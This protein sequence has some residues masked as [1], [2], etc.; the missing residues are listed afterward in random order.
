MKCSRFFRPS[1]SLGLALLAMLV[2]VPRTQAQDA[3]DRPKIEIVRS[4]PHSDDITSVAFSA[5]GASMLSGS[6]DKKVKLW[7]AATGALLRTLEG[8]SNAVWSVAFSPDGARVLSADGKVR[9]W[10]AA[11]GVVL[12]TFEGG[13][14]SAEFA[15]DGARVLI[16]DWREV[17]LWDA[18][19]GALLRTFE[20]GGAPAKFSP[21]GARVLTGSGR[22]VKLWDAARGALLRTFESSADIFSVAFS[23]DGSRVLSGGRSRPRPL[24]PPGTPLWGPGMPFNLEGFVNTTRSYADHIKLWDAATGALLRTFEHNDYNAIVRSVAFSPDGTRVLSGGTADLGGKSA[25]ILWD[26]ANMATS[27]PLRTFEGHSRSVGSVAFSPDGSR[28]LSGGDDRTV[29]LWDAATGAALHFATGLGEGWGIA[30]VA[31]SPDGARVLSSGSSGGTIRLRDAATGAQIRTFEGHSRTVSSVA[32]SPNGA[33]VLSSSYDETVRWWDAATGALVCTI[34]RQPSDDEL[35]GGVDSVALSP[36]GSRALLSGGW[37]GV[38]SLWDTTTCTKLRSFKGHSGKVV[39]VAFS[40]DGAR[41]LSGSNDYITSRG[42]SMR[43]WD[44]ATG[45]QLRTFE[46]SANVLSVAFS[47]DGTRVLSGGTDRTVKLWNPDGWWPS[48][49]PL[50]TFKGHSDSVT[51]VAFSPDGARVL[52]GSRDKT[53][54]LW[55]AATG[56][57]LRTF[58][59][60]SDGV[61]SIAFSADGRRIVSASDDATVLIW[62][63]A[64][65]AL[66]AS[67]IDGRDGRW[68][69]LTPAGF[70]TS[71][72]SVNDLLGIVRGL[73]LTTIDQVHQSLYNPDLVREAL[74]GDPGGEMAEAAK[75]VDLEKVLDSG[76]PPRVA[77]VSPTADS[78]SV[79]D[80]T[81]VVARIENRGKGVGRIEW[82]VNG[83]TAAV[84]AKPEGRGPV[85]T[86]T[87]QLSLD[88]GD[89]AIE[90]VAYN[91]SNLLASLPARITVKS[92]EPAGK[93]KPKLHI[94]AI[95][96][97]AY[98][99]R[100]WMP[101]GSEAPLG[102][103]PLDL[104]VKDAKAFAASMEKAAAGLYDKVRV[105]LALD[106]DASRDNLLKLI[107]KVAAQIH[108]RDTFI[109]FAAAHGY[110]LRGRF[111]LIPQDHQGGIN[112][113]ALAKRAIGQD[114]LQDWL[115][116]RIKAKRALI[117]LDACESGA[118]I[119]GHARSRTD[120]PASEAAVG[121]LHEAT[122]RP[123]LTAA[124]V[125]Q[126]AHEGEVGASGETHGYFTWAVLDALRN[127]DTN[128]NDLIELSELVSHVQTSV[129]RIAA[130]RG[131]RGQAVVSAPAGDKQAARFGSRGEDFVV[132]RRLQ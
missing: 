60:H 52:S 90:V 122:G 51:S 61:R 41:V 110:S 8:H 114:E 107:D 24:E 45:A 4:I 83:I 13:G 59:G 124:A 128:G 17:R 92:T 71:S 88:Q 48:W 12:R 96:I 120:G 31:F 98:E 42:Y 79:A 54:H 66:L 87:R 53:I 126:S 106:R 101:P 28:V 2:A 95:G 6:R 102:F 109:L 47:P 113:E 123:V 127:G 132:A 37:G 50:R 93:T 111:Y 112:P 118:L 99:D 27:R 119:A 32:F 80:L 70:F 10:D 23:P 67:F 68:L 65:G 69:A 15:P 1:L 103:D 73:D 121:R 58:E 89:N 97:D 130:K 35:F 40:P 56:A 125:G 33:R 46:N 116:N 18:A 25:I 38:L 94:L 19:T 9:L 7:D 63:A 39:S 91:G 36:D 43:L 26:L 57:L 77:I 3:A 62:N 86:V 30:S 117:L 76:P 20:G 85:Y 21:D 100:G 115:A 72:R 55:E 49:W 5:D 14:S 74:A 11:T 81:K 64:T 29:R 75:V 34:R 129:P 108:P 16:A 104:A 22:S 131:G 82:R 84:A 44:A 105:T 78:Q